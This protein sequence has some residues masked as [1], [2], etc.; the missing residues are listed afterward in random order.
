MACTLHIFVINSVRKLICL[1]YPQP[2]QVVIDNIT[3]AFTEWRN[4]GAWVPMDTSYSPC[5]L[6][7]SLLYSCVSQLGLYKSHVLKRQQVL[8]KN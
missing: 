8:H 6:T 7:I 5:R 4:S 2:K 1:S 3:C